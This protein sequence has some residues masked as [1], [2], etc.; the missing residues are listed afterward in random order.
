[1]CFSPEAS[2]TAA[3]LLVVAGYFTTKNAL[4]KNYLFLAIIPF[5][6]AFQQFIEGIVW[7]LLIDNSKNTDA[8]QSAKYAYLTFALSIWPV[9]IP[10]SL[11]AIEPNPRRAKYLK[12]LLMIGIIYSLIMLTNLF[13]LWP[14]QDVTVN[15]VNH[16]LQYDYPIHYIPLFSIFYFL[17]TILSPLLSSIK[18]INLLGIGYIITL[19]V[20]HY[21]YHTVF[22][23]VWC[24]FAAIVS[25]SIYFFIRNASTDYSKRLNENEIEK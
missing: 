13:L 11:F 15:I 21:F 16:S 5:I 24:F 8:L 25:I 19:G 14:S 4:K 2:F 6:F 1:M 3:A 17:P 10:L 20:A 7:T 12:V 22:V 18:G 9:W 23:S